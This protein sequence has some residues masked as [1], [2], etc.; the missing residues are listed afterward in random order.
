MK[1]KPKNRMLIQEISYEWLDY[2]SNKYKKSTY[3]SY[4]Y[5]I[6]KYIN[7]C[8]ISK[9]EISKISDTDMREYVDE[10]KGK[11]LSAKSVNDILSVFHSIVSYA[12]NKHSTKHIE[13][14]YLKIHNREM[15]VL[16]KY[17]QRRLETEL[18]KD[19]NNYKFG[20]LIA[21]YTGIRIG[22]LC[23]L[24]WKDIQQNTININKTVHRL[25]NGSK[26]EIVIDTPKTCNSN[27]SI[28][29]PNFLTDAIENRRKDELEYVL[30]SNMISF[31][32]P[33]LMQI[34]F[35]HI[36]EVCNIDGATFH[37][38]RHTFATR[39]VECG[40]DVKTLSEILGHSNVQTTLNR[41]VHSSMELKQQ[42]MDKLFQIAL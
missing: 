9:K 39:C 30:S 4:K 28:P 14:P 36:V 31:V 24:Q 2:D 35:K 11:Q 38:L 23:A 34:H 18:Y 25:K 26:T 10:L 12:E 29:I 15:R 22:E 16:S 6:N 7:S 41:Y 1:K 17:E 37:T 21:L 40:F 3:Q 27:R 8:E 42:N 19:M 13:I 5:I 32:E 33:R 20:V